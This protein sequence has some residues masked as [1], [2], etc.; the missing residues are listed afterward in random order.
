MLHVLKSY[1]ESLQGN[2]MYDEMYDVKELLTAL[3]KET[4]NHWWSDIDAIL[5]QLEQ[6]EKPVCWIDYGSLKSLQ[7]TVG[8][9]LRFLTNDVDNLKPTDVP[10]YLGTMCTFI[11]PPKP[12][13]GKEISVGFKADEALNAES[14]WAGV[15][16]AEQVHGIGN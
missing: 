14:Y 2:E 8:F 3:R 10:L 7:A 16:Y 11:P 12:L 15:A 1:N 13:S 5:A 4:D 9:A 6:E